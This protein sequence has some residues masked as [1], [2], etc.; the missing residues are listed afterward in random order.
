MQLKALSCLV[1]PGLRWSVVI[2]KSPAVFDAW[3][4]ISQM[5]HLS[6]YLPGNLALGVAEGAVRG[7]K[8]QLYAAVAA[9]LTYTCWQMYERMPSG[10][11]HFNSAPGPCK[12]H[13][14]CNARFASI[15]ARFAMANT[16]S[17][18]CISFE[19]DGILFRSIKRPRKVLRGC[20]YTCLDYL[21]RDC[22]HVICAPG[23]Y[24]T[25][26]RGCQVPW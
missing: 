3:L 20:L 7:K 11:A 14:Y 10:G 18:R 9:N 17:G 16:A 22:S 6:C 1:I 26:A 2:V 15:V 19:T 8:A 5:D 4:L 24:R 13:L 25:G 23:L 12:F 21:T